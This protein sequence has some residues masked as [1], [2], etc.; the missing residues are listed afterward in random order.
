MP[1][2]WKDPYLA[3]N[4]LVEIRGLIVAGFSEVRGLE[5]EVDVK[6]VEEGGLNN[7]VHQ[8]PGPTKASPRLVLKHG[9]IDS[10]ELW[11][12][13][14]GFVNAHVQNQKP[15]RRNVTIYL[16]NRAQERVRW[17]VFRDAFPVKWTGPD[18]NASS[19]AIAFETLELAHHGIQRQVR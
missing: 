12:W 5:V 1:R 2:V 13:H 9:M 16:Q 4:F 6:P 7:Y 17:W 8:L 14:Q 11:T 19:T 3:Y 10:R 18:L 15:E